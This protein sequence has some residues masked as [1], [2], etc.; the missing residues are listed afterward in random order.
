MPYAPPASRASAAAP[1]YPRPPLL[2]SPVRNRWGVGKLTTKPGEVY[3]GALG[4]AQ[5]NVPL[6]TFSGAGAYASLS[7]PAQKALYA[8][9]E[10]QRGYEGVPAGDVDG[11]LEDTVARAY[12]VQQTTGLLVD[13]LSYWDYYKTTGGPGLKNFDDAASA[14]GGSG[15]GGGGGGGGTSRSVNESVNL[16]DPSTARGLIDTTIARYLGRNPTD[17]EYSTFASALNAQE[18]KS[19]SITESVT[20]SGGGNSRTKS[21]TRG[22]MDR[23]QFAIEYAKSQE[24]VA[25]LSAATTGLDAFMDAIGG[26]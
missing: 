9:M 26:V 16:S 18:S 11:F 13:P 24:G 22:S 1:T 10:A 4:G 20:T 19:P 21:T 17:K 7:P 5:K 15:G 2:G 12:A 8:A 6:S 25:E 23:G 3:I 14:G